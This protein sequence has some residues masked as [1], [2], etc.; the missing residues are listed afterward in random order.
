MKRMLIII[1]LIVAASL[2]GCNTAMKAN[3]KFGM[4]NYQEAIALYKDYLAQ[5]PNDVSTRAR[6]A[7]AYYKLDRMEEA[8]KEAESIPSGY[9]SD[10]EV[11]LY[12]GE[13]LAASGDFMGASACFTRFRDA[14]DPDREK[15]CGDTGTI[16]RSIAYRMDAR[17]ALEDEKK[18]IYPETVSNRVVWT[19]YRDTS[20]DGKAM[21]PYRKALTDYAIRLLAA[22]GKTYEVISR[23]RMH[24]YVAEMGLE[25]ANGISWFAAHRLAAL[26]G[27]GQVIYGHLGM[28]SPVNGAF[29][30]DVNGHQTSTGNSGKERFAE[31]YRAYLRGLSDQDLSDESSHVAKMLQDSAESSGAVGDD[32][33]MTFGMVLGN[34]EAWNAYITKQLERDKSLFKMKLMGE[35]QAR[36]RSTRQIADLLKD[37]F[38]SV[39]EA[40]TQQT[41]AE[42]F[43]GPAGN[44]P[45][46]TTEI[47]D[48]PIEDIQRVMAKVASDLCGTEGS[49]DA[50]SVWPAPAGDH[51][52]K[53]GDWGSG[54]WDSSS[55]LTKEELA[56]SSEEMDKI[57]NEA[58]GNSNS[59]PEQVAKAAGEATTS[60]IVPG[61]SIGT[62]CFTGDT[63]VLRPDGG[64]IRIDQLEA[65]ARV[66]TWDQLSG[67]PAEAV[68]AEFLQ[69]DS[70]HYFL[71]NGVIK[72]TQHHR[73]L[74][75]QGEWVRVKDLKTGMILQGENGP[76]PV[77]SIILKRGH[78]P[79][80]NFDV[81]QGDSFLVAAGP[82]NWLVVH[83]GGGGGK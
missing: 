47:H 32:F 62:S 49:N 21:T 14:N 44:L 6:L 33:I 8:L 81:A 28:G 61:Q 54:I 68:V 35:E 71:I 48:Q 75:A 22:R 66:A 10:S 24:A 31:E 57:D 46:R 1:G 52:T 42:A 9:E 63:L 11:N 74:T 70:D 43:A 25:Y 37:F 27:S 78:F 36:R 2:S 53:I 67:R 39:R 38:A 26:T 16:L 17:K 19:Y 4:G 29:S 40:N 34:E 80:Y 20:R 69:A 82:G 55:M 76:L 7:Y 50:I 12:L 65:G 15:R 51:E 77:Q 64:R 83:N 79:V 23:E 58:R 30:M 72:V 5:N 60:A 13:I 56:K 3:L 45:G 18:G 59:K 41:A 73:V